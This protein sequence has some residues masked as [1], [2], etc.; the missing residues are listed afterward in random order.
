MTEATSTRSATDTNGY[1]RMNRTSYALCTM[2]YAPP[3]PHTHTVMYTPCT[4][5]EHHKREVLCRRVPRMG[6]WV[7]GTPPP[8]F[9]SKCR[10][11]LHF[12][13]FFPGR[14]PEP[15]PP[16]PPPLNGTG[17]RACSDLQVHWEHSLCSSR[18]EKQVDKI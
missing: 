13:K 1:T 6:S 3:P 8:L 7:P 10:I 5:H 18:I 14:L 15:L 2:L 11:L 12:W 4:I 16:P 9:R 17:A